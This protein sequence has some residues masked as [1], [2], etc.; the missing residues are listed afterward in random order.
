[1]ID[2]ALS[3]MRSRYG[4]LALKVQVLCQDL[5]LVHAPAGSGSLLLHGCVL[6]LHAHAVFTYVMLQTE[7]E[8]ALMSELAE[9][10]YVYLQG[11]GIF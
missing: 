2:M 3:A 9:V 11:A 5:C 8:Q 7:L 1:M 10:Q 6:C 4:M